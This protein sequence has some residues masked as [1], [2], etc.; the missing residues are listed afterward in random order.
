[1]K[2]LDHSLQSAPE[3]TVD[4]YDVPSIRQPVIR[5]ADGT[6]MYLMIVHTGDSTQAA[7]ER[8]PG[9]PI[10]VTARSADAS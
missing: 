6:A 1:M 9:V 5:Y 7:R 8:E 10:E 3:V 4:H 2:L